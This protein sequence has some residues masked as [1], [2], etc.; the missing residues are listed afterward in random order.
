M[1]PI[2]WPLRHRRPTI[3]VTLPQA[4]GK[5]VRRLIADTGAGTDQA[6]FELLLREADCRGSGNPPVLGLVHLG[7][8]YSGWFNVY[9]LDV[10]I[11]R[12]GFAEAVAVVGVPH[13]P[14]GFDGIACFKFLN[15]FHYGNFGDADTFGL[16]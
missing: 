10:R 15:R 8:A 11:S 2:R 4:K 6:I 1:P 5:R 12:L 9:S 7:G 13:V 14:E 3:A 16:G